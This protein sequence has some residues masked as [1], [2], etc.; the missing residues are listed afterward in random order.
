MAKAKAGQAGTLRREPKPKR[1]HQGQ[2]HNSRPNHGRK[3]LRGQG[4]G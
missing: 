4:R 1:T 2:G 3:Q